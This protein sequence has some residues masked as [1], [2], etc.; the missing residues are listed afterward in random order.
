MKIISFDA[1][2]IELDDLVYVQENVQENA[3]CVA[4]F[5]VTYPQ[6]NTAYFMAAADGDDYSSI[7]IGKV[8]YDLVLRL[9]I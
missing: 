4:Y 8:M 1:H 7:S 5:Q 3:P 9:N 6:G 2:L